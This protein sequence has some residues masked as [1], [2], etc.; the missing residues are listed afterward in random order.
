M[1]SI[2]DVCRIGVFA[3][4][5]RPQAEEEFKAEAKHWMGWG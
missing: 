1:Y 2:V 3:L 4:A 5:I